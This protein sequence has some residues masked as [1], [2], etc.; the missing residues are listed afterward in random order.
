MVQMF[1]VEMIRSK[2]EALISQM[3]FVLFRSAYSALMRESRDCSFGVCS[4]EGDAPFPTARVFTTTCHHIRSTFSIED[5]HDGDMFLGNNP[6]ET[7]IQH[8]P[9]TVVIAPVFYEGHLMAFCGSVAHKSDIGGAVPGSVY[10]GA[11][12]LQQ[13]GL[14]LPVMKYYE[15]GVLVRQV[16]EVIRSN[17]RN[18]D[19]VLGDL[20]AQIG[21]TFLAV[22]QTKAIITKHGMQTVLDAFQELLAVSERRVSKIVETWPGIEAEAEAWLDPPPNHDKPVRFHVRVTR[23]GG[24][25]TFDFTG[26]DPQVRNPVNVT[27]PFLIGTLCLCVLG[28]TNPTITDNAGVSRA[29]SVV[30]EPGRVLSPTPPA[31][32]GN[33]T[34]VN[35]RIMDVVLKALTTMR[36]EGPIAERGGHGTTAFGWRRGLVEG[37]TYIQYEIHNGAGIGA[38]SLGDGFSSGNPHGYALDR[39]TLDSRGSLDAPVE[40]LESQYPVRIKRFELLP[41]SGG[42][43]RLRGGV[44]RSKVY[45]ALAPATLNVRH[46]MGFMLPPQG[47]SGGEPGRMGRVLINANTPRAVELHDWKYELEVGDTVTFEAAGGGGVGNPFERDPGRVQTDVTEGLI[48]PE[49][50]RRDYGVALVNTNGSFAVDVNET[51]R[52]RLAGRSQNAGHGT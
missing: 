16:E 17:V 41:D 39:K 7:G 43:G 31:P 36:G 49:S 18:P 44:A 27:T 8:T 23:Q 32:T 38:S 24:H 34:M 22:A 14:V 4:P 11:T 19:V 51:E 47:A 50:A 6:Y 20:G 2:F 33:T 13:E 15:E 1:E 28:L 9:D 21:A 45:E 46:A 25:L 5:I 35:P 3:R 12:E 10:S 30:V 52:L 40:I 48:S 29:F 42:A 37:R 26:S